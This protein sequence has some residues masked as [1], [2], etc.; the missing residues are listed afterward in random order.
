MKHSSLS[1]KKTRDVVFSWLY[2]IFRLLLLCGI[3]YIVLY[4][5]LII[6][7]TSLKSPEELLANSS[8]FIPSEPTFSNYKNSLEVF[9]YVKHLG[10][11]I[12]MATIST[13]I[14]VAICSLVGYGLGRFQFKGRNLVYAAVLFTIIMPI[15]TA[16]IPLYY[17]YRWFDF[18][19][20]GKIVGLFTGTPLTINLNNDFLN[21]FVPALFGVGLNSGI[22]IFLF[23]Q[24][25]VSMPRDLEEA[26]KLDGC[27]P[28]QIYLKVMLPNIKPVI[29]TVAL[30]SVIYYWN[31]TLIAGMSNLSDKATVTLALENL[32]LQSS[33]IRERLDAA[34]AQLVYY[35][36]MSLTILPLVV[37]FTICQR[38]FVEC[39]DRSGAKG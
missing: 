37:L 27:H 17:Y 30:L 16:Q 4:P 39:L 18:F 28:F 24:F 7:S 38:F 2:K 8:V 25:F 35:A 21:Y 31:D 1:V 34:N 15:Q 13:F 6:I 32:M 36:S 9:N 5:V 14:Q 11:T 10:W 12:Y 26:A 22:F 19:G 33:A 3:S 20:I 23:R 29:V